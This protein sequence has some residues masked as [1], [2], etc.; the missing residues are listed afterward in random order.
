[1]FDILYLITG[2]KEREISFASSL[3]DA[4]NTQSDVV[5]NLQHFILLLTY[6]GYGVLLVPGLI[7]FSD[8]GS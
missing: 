2:F 6:H 8:P 5:V 1:M 3:P 4:V 7:F